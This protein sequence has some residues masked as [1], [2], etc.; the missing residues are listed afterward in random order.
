MCQSGDFSLTSDHDLFF[1][2]LRNLMYIHSWFYVL[3]IYYGQEAGPVGIPFKR[4]DA[5]TTVSG[6]RR[7]SLNVFE[8]YKTVSF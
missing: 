4:P 3:V 1:E 8:D 7:T 5:Q 6:L 2:L